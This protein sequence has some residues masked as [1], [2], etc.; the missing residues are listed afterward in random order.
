MGA[1]L[2]ACI[3]ATIHVCINGR[4]V[5]LAAKGGNPFKDSRSHGK[6]DGRKGRGGQGFKRDEASQ[7]SADKRTSTWRQSVP[8]K[9]REVTISQP[10]AV[11]LLEEGKVDILP[12][13]WCGDCSLKHAGISCSVPKP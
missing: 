5:V 6:G 12:D 7:P 13:P 8:A 10:L 4:L 3:A 9:P 2:R 1:Y 11:T